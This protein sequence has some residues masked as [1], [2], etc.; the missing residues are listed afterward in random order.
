MPILTSVSCDCGCKRTID[1]NQKHA[2]GAE[3]LL[4]ITDAFGGKFFFLSK[5][6]LLKWLDEVYKEPTADFKFS[7]DE[8]SPLPGTAVH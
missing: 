5:A 6:C 7:D 4:Q 8:E 2:P 1:L 3:L